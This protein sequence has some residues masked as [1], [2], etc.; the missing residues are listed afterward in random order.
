MII[1]RFFRKI[2]F[3]GFLFFNI[4]FL[5][6]G[7][8]VNTYSDFSFAEIVLS[9]DFSGTDLPGIEMLIDEVK[10]R[11]LIELNATNQWPESDIP[12]IV[13]GTITSLK[14]DSFFDRY[15]IELTKSFPEGFIIRLINNDGNSPKLFIAGN[16]NRGLLY[17]IGY[18][19]R[20]VTM[21]KGKILVPDSIDIET[22]PSVD[23]RGHQMGYRPKTNS[24]CGFDV[25]MWEQYIRDLIVFG[26]NA[27]ELLPPFTD[28]DRESP[29]FTLPPMEMMTEMSNIMDKYHIDVWIW[30]PLMYGDYSRPENVK[31]SLQENEE[32]FSSLK[33]IDAVFVPGGDPGH[34]HPI[35]LFDYLE[36]KA[37]I[38]HQFHPEAEV[39]LS[40]QGFDEDWMNEFFRLLREEPG[41][42]TGVVHGPQ[43]SYEVNHFREIVPA[44]Y[45]I[46]LY[47]D[48]THTYDAQYPVPDWDFAFA[49]TQNREPIN[50]RPID[51][52]V[53]F[54]SAKMENFHGFITY[55]EGVNDDVNKIIWNGLGW[56]PDADI[57]E[58]LRDYSRYFIGPD[59]EIDFAQGI[60]NL[61]QNWKG[62]L[63]S[64]GQVL[65]N[66]HI[67]ESMEKRADPSVRFNWR[68]Q[69]ALYRSYYDA[70]I[71]SRLLY[72]TQLEYEAMDILRQ[73]RE[74]GSIKAMMQAE[75]KLE[76]AIYEKVAPDRK[77]RLFELAEALFHSIKM[78][79]SVEK[80]FASAIRRGANLDLVEYPLNNRI[81]LTQQ[82]SRIS[83]INSE[84]TRLEEI[85]KIINWTNPGPGGFYTDLGDIG[86][87]TNLVLGESYEDDP[88]FLSSPFIGFT[89]FYSN[90][91][92]RISWQ[93]HM[94][95]LYDQPLSMYY[96]NLDKTAQY[97]VKVTYVRDLYSGR[98]QIQ[99]LG[100]DIQVHPYIDKPMEVQPLIF[101]IPME[102][103]RNGELTL[104]WISEPGQGGTGRGCQI[105]EVWLMKK[106]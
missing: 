10:K 105:A 52:S 48:I 101:D 57:L 54:R 14:N 13:I 84:R 46:R 80:Y 12:V 73:S 50:P 35:L 81:W 59:Y 63:I 36:K 96:S 85:D 11:T 95:T 18:F 72:E 47:P 98:Q 67:F 40:P 44:K 16:D 56:D 8:M 103:T 53:I 20:K 94:Q 60:L 91:T 58:I 22:Y 4:A 74:L 83:Q 6:F 62:P 32:I 89:V 30:Y 70:Y 49:A 1:N 37:G 45:P 82:F 51:Q 26:T 7:Q 2:V 100:D 68:F 69:M 27:I 17:G 28:D 87:Q 34:T 77:Q 76:Q 97:E 33:R 43:V 23:L 38:L 61:E 79:L 64:N 41:W 3:I 93:R 75:Q 21:N 29:M 90:I 66:H 55:S 15:N 39:W 104:T 106:K 92:G 9:K 65:V 24:Y 86:N 25:P 78:Q 19:L 31:K 99:L 71:K 5:G 88:Q 102:A 42:L